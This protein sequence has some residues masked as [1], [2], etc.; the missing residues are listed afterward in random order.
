[1][2]CQT[3][4]FVFFALPASTWIWALI[5]AVTIHVPESSGKVGEAMMTR[6]GAITV[7]VGISMLSYG[8]SASSVYAETVEA[9]TIEMR[10]FLD[11]QGMFAVNLPKRF[12]AIRRTAQGDLPDAKGKG[13]RGSTIF[14]A[15][16]MSKAE[17][18]AVERFPTEILLIDNGIQPTGRLNL[19][20]DIGDPRAVANLLLLKRDRDK[21]GATN[22]KLEP[23]SVSM[24]EDQEELTF[25]L[26]TQIEVQRPELLLEQTGVAELFRITAAKASLRAGD[27]VMM[28]VYA[29]ALEND[30]KGLDGMALQE[31]VKS[32]I[33]LG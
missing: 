10:T 17:V 5:P 14:S 6:R 12:F 18:V 32:F 1:M 16:D 8:G 25:M 21:D 3:L 9:N 26:R 28:V 31:A 4:S 30:W 22:T 15:G 20:T 7:A 29:S 27:G 23:E 24:S 13:R 19:I 2:K 33:V 11:P